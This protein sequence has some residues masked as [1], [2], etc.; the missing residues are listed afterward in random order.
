MTSISPKLLKAKGIKLLSLDKQK[1]LLSSLTSFEEGGMWLADIGDHPWSSPEIQARSRDKK[2]T[3][4]FLCPY[5]GLPAGLS[6][7]RP[8]WIFHFPETKTCRALNI[9]NGMPALT[10]W[11]DEHSNTRKPKLEKDARKMVLLL[12]SLWPKTVYEEYNVRWAGFLV[13]DSARRRSINLR[14]IEPVSRYRL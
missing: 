13:K 9:W 1:M 7:G 10:Y 12:S 8:T 11:E 14:D 5:L 6:R 4:I 2:A 3:K